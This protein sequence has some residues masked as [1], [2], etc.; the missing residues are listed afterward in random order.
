MLA[1]GFFFF[2]TLLLALAGGEFPDFGEDYDY[3]VCDG[4]ACTWDTMYIYFDKMVQ[5]PNKTVTYEEYEYF[6]VDTAGLL[7]DCAPSLSVGA[8]ATTI[9]SCK[10]VDRKYRN[11]C[12]FKKKEWL[13][14]DGKTISGSLVTDFDEIEGVSE[15]IAKCLDWDGVYKYDYDYNY[16]Y[17]YDYDYYGYLEESD[18]NQVRTKRD[19][20]S[21]IP[22]FLIQTSRNKR[23]SN[24]RGKNGV[25]SRTQGKRQN[26]KNKKG[27]QNYKVHGKKEKKRNIQGKKGK[28]NGQ[29]GK[30]RNNQSKKGNKPGRKRYNS[31]KNGK[32]NGNKQGKK[33]KNSDKKGKQYKKETKSKKAKDKKK[34]KKILKQLG[35]NSNPSEETLRKLD[36]AERAIEFGLEKCGE[37]I[38]EEVD[39]Q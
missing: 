28:R 11:A 24:K 9:K 37:K 19:I 32:R 33:S 18:N 22:E 31:D 21:N 2:S 25:K 10:D 15:N 3:Y 13:G 16:D 35:L 27:M 30:K 29:N 39:L 4:E 12:K 20:K 17:D 7:A 14:Q 36:C 6:N 8:I 5:V 38:F 1:V 23:D 34:E 26:N